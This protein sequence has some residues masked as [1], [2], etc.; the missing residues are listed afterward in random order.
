M[1]KVKRT[2][3]EDGYAYLV[4][5]ACRDDLTEPAG[6]FFALLDELDLK[7]QSDCEPDETPPGRAATL[8]AAI[9]AFAAGR[10]LPYQRYNR[11]RDGV[12]E[13]KARNARLSFY[14]T[15]GEGCYIPKLGEDAGY[16]SGIEL[17]AF[18][19]NIRLGHGFFK[20]SGKTSP[21]DI[22]MTLK[23]REED[24]GRD[25]EQNSELEQQPDRELER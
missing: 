14:D 1:T 21:G 6:T 5:Y 18:D 15:D 16:W 4:E 13:F 12:W 9:K 17:P 23:V 8:R 10:R 19:D 25:Y 11:L 22:N 7:E 2:V 24:I 20:N 3:V